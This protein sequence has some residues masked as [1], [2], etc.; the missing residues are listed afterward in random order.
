MAIATRVLLKLPPELSQQIAVQSLRVIAPLLPRPQ[1]RPSFPALYDVIG[2]NT[3]P[4]EERLRITVMGLNFPNPIGLA[5]GLDK[6]ALLNE[7]V[8]RL[9]FG[10]AECGTITPSSQPGNLPPRLFRLES[11][12]AVINRM[13]FN[14]DGADKAA[15]RLRLRPHFGI[16]GINIGSGSTTEDRMGDYEKTFI[17]LAPYADYVTVNVSSPNT[18]GLRT[19]QN[20]AELSGLLFALTKARSNLERH[21]PILLKIAPDIDDVLADEIAEVSLG[22][23]VDGLIVSNTTVARPANLRSPNASKEGGLSGAPLFDRSTSLLREMRRR[24]GTK[25]TLVGAGGVRSGNDAYVKIRAGASLIQMYTAFAYN[26]TPLVGRLKN[27]LNALLK[28]DGFSHV[29]DAVGVDV[30]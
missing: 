11:D 24:V 8:L 25:L 13:G 1:A 21:V 23:D 7:N 30:R 4:D 10:F 29:S 14:N 15:Q 3:G 20:R 16:L 12:H 6:D 22:A 26:G 27:E 19:L 9:G 17:K 28:R 2:I 18:L 5:A